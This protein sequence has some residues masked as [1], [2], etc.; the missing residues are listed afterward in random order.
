MTHRVYTHTLTP[1]MPGRRDWKKVL[2]SDSGHGRGWGWVIDGGWEVIGRGGVG[3]LIGL[4]TAPLR[5]REETQTSPH[6]VPNQGY[7]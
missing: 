7:L 3:R 1:R 6:T 5:S 2:S 4:E